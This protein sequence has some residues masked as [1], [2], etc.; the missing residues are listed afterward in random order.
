MKKEIIEKIIKE[1]KRQ[2]EKWGIQDH[3]SITE[4]EGV[5]LSEYYDIPSMLEAQKTCDQQSENKEL[6]WT[7]ILLEEFCEVVEAPNEEL[8]KT[9][10]VEVISV[11]IA[12]YESIERKQKIVKD[13]LEK[14]AFEEIIDKEAG[15]I[16]AFELQREAELYLPPN[17]GNKI[18]IMEKDQKDLLIEKLE[19]Y[20][21]FIAKEGMGKWASYLYAHSITTTKDVVEEGERRRNEIKELKDGIYK[22]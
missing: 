19:S 2:D 5:N 10:L 12:W 22:K 18:K 17:D 13:K 7:D 6:T 15:W 1:R 3:P 20:I 8:R 11:A 21:E 4:I 9:E 14:E 16:K